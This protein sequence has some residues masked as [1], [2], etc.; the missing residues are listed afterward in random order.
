MGI[1]NVFFGPDHRQAV[2]EYDR[3]K[4][5]DMPTDAVNQVLG[6]W[7]EN[8]VAIRPFLYEVW[9]SDTDFVGL[10]VSEP[11]DALEDSD[12]LLQYDVVKQSHT[13]GPQTGAYASREVEV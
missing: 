11:F 4:L 5:N 8:A 13:D 2:I 7:W 10:L 6:V 3:H 1:A 12:I 9:K